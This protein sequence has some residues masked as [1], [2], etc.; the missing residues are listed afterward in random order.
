MYHIY[1]PNCQATRYEK[2]ISDTCNSCK[3]NYCIPVKLTKEQ[4]SEVNKIENNNK[5]L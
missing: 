4:E 2:K 5:T 3:F 1:C